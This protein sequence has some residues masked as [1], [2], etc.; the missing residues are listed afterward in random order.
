[1]KTILLCNAAANQRAL[2]HRL[3]A[4][5][6]LAAI[7][8]IQIPATPRKDRLRDRFASVSVGL[9]LRRAWFGML[10]HYDKA[11]PGF[12]DVPTAVHRGVNADTVL[13][14]VQRERP[15][16]VLV[17]GTNLLKPP[18]INEIGRTGRILNLHTGISPYIKG[19]PNCTNWAL[20]LG[21]FGLIGNT[22]MW[23]NAGIDSG[24]IVSTER[25]P[26]TGF[27]TLFQLQLKVMDH[28]HDL[29]CRCARRVG[30]GTAVP[31]LPQSAL[32][33]GRV[34][35]SK[36]WTAKQIAKAVYNFYRTY[37]ASSL[38]GSQPHRLV[39]LERA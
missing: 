34:F 37:H 19:G 9:P 20:A 21:E 31:S 38:E 18:L 4:V 28:A 12:P 39:P 24:N 10:D 11:F 25:T 33:P 1:M 7:G 22:V 29:Y 15:E 26:L 23:L 36:D 13:D 16:I 30:E 6:P 2:A 8:I 14:L 5:A 17:S 27:E 35:L 3:H 32:G